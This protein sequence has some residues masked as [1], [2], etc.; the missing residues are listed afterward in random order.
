MYW[1]TLEAA[2]LL[3][4]RNSVKKKHFII[5]S[6][7]IALI[8]NEGAQLVFC[9][10]VI[11]PSEYF[12]IILIICF[13]IVLFIIFIFTLEVMLLLI[14][15]HVANKSYCFQLCCFSSYLG[16]GGFHNTEVLKFYGIKLVKLLSFSFPVFMKCLTFN[17]FNS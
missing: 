11:F 8:T 15:L 14:V 2:T 5:T 13:S 16:H 9:V 4:F 12:L 10:S 6:L 3:I 7:C 1:P 17:H